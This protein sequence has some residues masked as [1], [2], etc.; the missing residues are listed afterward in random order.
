MIPVDDVAAPPVTPIDDIVCLGNDADLIEA[1]SPQ[2]ANFGVFAIVADEPPAR[3][4]R[5]DA[6][7]IHYNRWV[8][9]GGTHADVARA[10]RDVPVRSALKAG[11][12]AWFVGAGGPMGRMHVQRAIQ[13]PAGPATVVCTD[14]SDLRL[15]D[16]AESFG[17]E[18]RAKGIEFICLNPLQREAFEAAMARFRQG[19]FDDIMV[20]AP[21]PAIMSDSARWLAPTRRQ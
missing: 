10:Y 15:N 8:Y 5:I 3:P 18:A 11:G 20:L 2:L 7:R 6:G 13:V 9:V 12:A 1:A 4:V 21:V 19:G 14:V 17:E 16:L